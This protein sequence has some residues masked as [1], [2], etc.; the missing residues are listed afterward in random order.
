M[1]VDLLMVGPAHQN[2][3]ARAMPILIGLVGVVPRATFIPGL[4]VA[5]LTDDGIRQFIHQSLGAT[6]EGA[7]IA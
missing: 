2:Q 4:Y 5:D 1:L 3:V 7:S 6:W